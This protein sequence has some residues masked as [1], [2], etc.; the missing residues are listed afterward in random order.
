MNIPLAAN[1]GLTQWILT[2]EPD[3]ADPAAE[4]RLLSSCETLKKPVLVRYQD[5]RLEEGTAYGVASVFTYLHCRGKGY[6]QILMS[7]LGET[8]Q[9][10]QDGSSGTAVCSV[11]YS[12]IGKTFYDRVG[13]KPFES[14]HLEFSASTA[15]S[16]LSVDV[17]VAVRPVG[18]DDISLLTS[19]D[20][21]SI[22]RKL[23]SLDTSKIR[24]ALLPDLNTVLWFL[25]REDLTCQQI[26]AQTPKVRGALYTPPATPN[27]RVWGLWFRGFYGGLAHPEK[28]T[29]HFLRLAVED[30]DMSDEQLAQGLRAILRV[31]CRE[32]HEW[33][34]LKVELWNPEPRVRKLVENLQDLPSKF[35]ERE[36]DS[37]S[38]LRWFGEGSAK[39]VDWLYNEKFGW[40]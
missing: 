3:A 30:D 16:D 36:V 23:S 13:W 32:G 7:K 22:R 10:S 18:D 17:E 29:L 27:S 28:N 21:Q 9:Q 15:S 35:V 37:I 1:G 5:G 2:T 34:C 38:S 8:L 26:F 19:L 25:R 39:D 20:E 6:A 14:D 12:D 31:A 40:C 33:R 11:L 24:V 4:R